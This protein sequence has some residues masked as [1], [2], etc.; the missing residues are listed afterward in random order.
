MNERFCKKAKIQLIVNERKK[1]E[2]KKE[3]EKSKTQTIIKEMEKK[4]NQIYET[5]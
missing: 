4:H 1:K 5:K 2:W 3:W